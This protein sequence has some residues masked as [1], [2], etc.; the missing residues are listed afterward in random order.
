MA[1]L[2]ST[3]T[4]DLQ[5]AY[6]DMTSTLAE[7][8]INNVHSN[9][10]ERLGLRTASVN[11]SLTAGTREYAYAA[12]NIHVKQVYYV[13][14]SATN[15]F[16]LLLPTSEDELDLQNRI[17]RLSTTQGTPGRYYM[18]SKT[19][20]DN[21]ATYMG[22]DPIPDTSTSAGCPIVTIY[23]VQTV[24]LTATDTIPVELSSSQVYL[25]GAKWIHCKNTRRGEAD[26]WREQYDQSMED[27]VS[28]YNDRI[29][30]YPSRFHLSGFVKGARVV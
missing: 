6:D 24:T 5:M 21:T 29:R 13:F 1:D 28:F 9:V 16:K 3:L 25:D 22:F 8:Y 20:T 23:G 26:Y 19:N 2:V 12:V 17:W 27:E 15:D 18:I 4:T 10:L 11:I 14:S 30:N 7:R